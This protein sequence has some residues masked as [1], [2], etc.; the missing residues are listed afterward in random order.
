MV[1]HAP[2]AAGLARAAVGRLA[3]IFV[4]IVNRNA[5]AAKRIKKGQL[6]SGD[7]GM[8]IHQVWRIDVQ[9]QVA[10]VGATP[11]QVRQIAEGHE[12]VTSGALV[13]STQSVSL[14][15]LQAARSYK[16]GEL[17]HAFDPTRIADVGPSPPSREV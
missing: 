2:D 16:T 11:M 9:S 5:S 6:R 3:H 13:L 12:F 4:T 7:L 1:T 17:V 8:S 14:K 10:V 15:D